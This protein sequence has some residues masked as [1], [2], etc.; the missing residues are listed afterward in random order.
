MSKIEEFDPNR[1]QHVGMIENFAIFGINEAVIKDYVLE[2][3][4]PNEF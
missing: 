1:K 4:L 2:G 3:K